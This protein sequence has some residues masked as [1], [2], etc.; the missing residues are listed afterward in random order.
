MRRA[1]HLSH[2]H[3][4]WRRV[5]GLGGADFINEFPLPAGASSPL[6]S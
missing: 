5:L 4:E 3:H 2:I 1:I 6:F